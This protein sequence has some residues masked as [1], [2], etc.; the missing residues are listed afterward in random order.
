MWLRDDLLFQ[1]ERKEWRE[2]LA[3]LT[4]IPNLQIPRSIKLGLFSEAK[5]ELHAFCDASETALAAV[6]Y[7][8]LIKDVEMHIQTGFGVFTPS[9]V[10]SMIKQ[11]TYKRYVVSRRSNRSQMF[12]FAAFV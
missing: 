11:C 6:V 3:G 9:S 5:H 2:W 1:E 12:I 10:T 4:I 8:R 7:L